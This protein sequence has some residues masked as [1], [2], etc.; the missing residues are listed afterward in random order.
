[1]KKIDIDIYLP[2]VF[3]DKYRK[4]LIKVVEMCTVKRNLVDPPV[5]QVNDM[6]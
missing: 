6:S 4:G 3:P 2:P 1:M 5:I